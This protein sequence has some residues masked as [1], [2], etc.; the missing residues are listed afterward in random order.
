[1]ARTL[2]RVALFTTPIWSAPS[3]AVDLCQLLDLSGYLLAVRLANTLPMQGRLVRLWTVVIY[4]EQ[5]F[6]MREDTLAFGLCNRP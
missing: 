4:D 2:Q 1:M 5:Q 3:A 6:E